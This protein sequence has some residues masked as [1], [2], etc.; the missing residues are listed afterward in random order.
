[1]CNGLQF[2]TLSKPSGALWAV[3]QMEGEQNTCLLKIPEFQA[4]LACVLGLCL[5][6]LVDQQH[7]TDLALAREMS[8]RPALAE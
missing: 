8:G 6:A 1:M 5:L 4:S 2:P 7:C 3:L